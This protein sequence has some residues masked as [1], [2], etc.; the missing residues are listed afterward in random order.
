M[1]ITK[2]MYEY[3]S[4]RIEELLPLTDD[5]TPLDDQNMIQILI[6]SDVVERYEDIHYPFVPLSA[7]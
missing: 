1:E 4:A 7:E 2:E 6:Y 3:A 5:N